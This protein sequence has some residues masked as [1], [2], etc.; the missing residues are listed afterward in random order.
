M[1]NLTVTIGV[2]VAGLLASSMA[3]TDETPV[4]KAI[5]ANADHT[6]AMTSKGEVYCWGNNRDGQLGPNVRGERSS[7]PQLVPG[8]TDATSVSCSARSSCALF[9]NGKVMC[10]GRSLHHLSKGPSP[11]VVDDAPTAVAIASGGDHTCLLLLDGT[12]QCWGGNSSG[13]IGQKGGGTYGGPV[14]VSGHLEAIGI[15]AGSDHTCALQK[16]G[17]V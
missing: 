4:V 13:Q 3:Y 2:F 7:V 8:V 5:A 16:N 11:I 17:F 14:P 10:W 15:A 9:K 12:V 1:K 6:C